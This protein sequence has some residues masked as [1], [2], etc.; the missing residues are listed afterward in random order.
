MISREAEEP[1]PRP[2]HPRDED[3]ASISGTARLV[4]DPDRRQGRVL[5][6]A[7]RE[8]VKIGTLAPQHQA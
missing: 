5:G 1:G 2:A 8:N 6:R 7:L 3:F 4:H